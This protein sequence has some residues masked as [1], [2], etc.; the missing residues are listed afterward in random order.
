MVRI[1]R[2]C[3]DVISIG[4][5]CTLALIVTNETKF[6]Y[7]WVWSTGGIDSEKLKNRGIDIIRRTPSSWTYHKI[8]QINQ[9]GKVPRIIQQW[10]GR[11]V[12]C[13]MF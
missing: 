12:K 9:S 13:I 5:D 11:Q 7:S 4:V 1:K 3:F 6:R 2:D 8:I 10:F